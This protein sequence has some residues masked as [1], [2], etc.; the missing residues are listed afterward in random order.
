MTSAAPDRLDRIE[1]KL[2]EFI[3]TSQAETAAI[4]EE[5]AALKEDIKR[6]SGYFVTM[7]VSVTVMA[8]GA[9]FAASAVVILKSLAGQ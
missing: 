7:A 5:T 9:I 8:T 2:D 3:A 1:Q 4:K 6:F